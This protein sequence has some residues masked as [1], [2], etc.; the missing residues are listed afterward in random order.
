MW[1]KIRGMSHLLV[2]GS[3]MLHNSPMAR[4]EGEGEGTGTVNNDAGLAEL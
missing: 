2:S 3:A 1:K 4:Y